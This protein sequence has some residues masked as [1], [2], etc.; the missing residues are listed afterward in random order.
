M[1]AVRRSKTKLWPPWSWIIALSV[2]GGI[3]L[4][5]WW[6]LPDVKSLRTTRPTTTALI[7]QRKE[8]AAQERRRFA[9]RLTWVPLDRIAPVLQNA[10]VL[11]EDAAFWGHDGVDWFELQEAV[12]EDLRT[13]SFRRGASTITQQLAKNL[14]YGT[15]KSLSRKLFELVVTMQLEKTLTKKEILTTYLNVIEWGDGVFGIEAGAHRHFGVGAAQLSPAQAAVMAAML[16][17]PRKANLKAPSQWLQRRSH[18]VLRLL[19]ATHRLSDAEHTQARA[20]LDRLMGAPT[21]GPEEIPVEDEE[22]PL[23]APP[24]ATPPPVAKAAEEDLVDEPAFEP[25]EKHEEPELEASPPEDPPQTLR[26][27]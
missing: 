21:V 26:E 7:E 6:A 12:R 1:R 17:A 8:E 24:R 22:A 13:L 18:H 15:R 10:V 20:E 9:P 4:A 23:A 2:V 3:S 16:P 25:N 27:P 19:H 5:L 14:Y 11:S